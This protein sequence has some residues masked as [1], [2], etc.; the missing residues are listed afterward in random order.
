[1]KNQESIAL[2]P[3]SFDPFTIGHES[4]VKRGSVLFDKI[5]IGIGINS[6]K[7]SFFSTE[8]RIKIIEKTFA[9]YKNISVVI[10]PGLTVDYCKKNGINYILRGLRTASDFEYERAIGQ[11]NK[12]LIQQVE[13]IFLLTEPEHTPISSS[14]VREILKY[15][16]D[17]S[18][19]VPKAVDIS[20]Y[21]S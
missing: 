20:D 13:T 10:Y 11:M 5:I 3:G 18:D 19:F 1:M 16:G 21:L 12:K 7:H 14:V 2:F 6:E 8:N 17:V 15:K 4:I 9:D